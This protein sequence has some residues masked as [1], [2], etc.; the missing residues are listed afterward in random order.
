MH[1]EITGDRNLTQAQN[2]RHYCGAGLTDA[3][4]TRS[5][6]APVTGTSTS[7]MPEGWGCTGLGIINYLHNAPHAVALCQQTLPSRKQTEGTETCPRLCKH[8]PPHQDLI[9]LS[10]SNNEVWFFCW[11]KWIIPG[12]LAMLW[13]TSSHTDTWSGQSNHAFPPLLKTTG[14][15]EQRPWWTRL[16]D[17]QYLNLVRLGRCVKEPVWP[18]KGR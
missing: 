11:W 5:L 2:P 18:C 3:Q 13:L 7:T 15:D 1:G 9:L 12:C 16:P 6:W 4:G 14:K 17:K 10:G 8:H